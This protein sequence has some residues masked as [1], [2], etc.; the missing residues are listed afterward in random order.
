MG[1][2]DRIV[3]LHD[4]YYTAL[5]TEGFLHWIQW[6]LELTVALSFIPRTCFAC[7]VP[8]LFLQP[9]VKHL[10]S[11]CFSNDTE[12]MSERE[13]RENESWALLLL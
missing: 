10:V 5:A 3:S 12:E 1:C 6:D 2:E 13:L 8:K 9:A 7:S 4:F 11:V